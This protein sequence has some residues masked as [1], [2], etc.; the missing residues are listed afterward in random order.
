MSRHNPPRVLLAF[1]VVVGAAIAFALRVGLPVVAT[2]PTTSVHFGPPVD[3]AA[4]ASAKQAATPLYL[5]AQ[6]AALQDGVRTPGF[7][8]P[9]SL[10][11]IHTEPLT[12]YW[13]LLGYV[14][15]GF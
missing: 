10:T 12:C 11:Q 15:F 13:C 4:T 1:E 7:L 6:S 14:T 8:V 3:M 2:A 5:S 9:R